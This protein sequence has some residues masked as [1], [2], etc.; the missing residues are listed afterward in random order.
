MAKWEIK[1]KKGDY[2][3]MAQVLSIDENVSKILIN[4]DINTRRKVR[5]YLNSELENLNDF[6]KMKDVDKAVK[7]L[8]N[9]IDK[10]KKITIYGDYDVDGVCSTTILYKGLKLL[11]QNISYYIP[12][13][14]TEGYGLNKK[15]I[16]KIK[17]EGSNLIITCDNGI[18]SFEE[19]ELAKELGMDVIIIDH[20]DTGEEIPKADSVINAKQEQCEFKFKEM[21][22]GGVSYRFIK[23]YLGKRNVELI[24]H[25]ELLVFSMIATFCDVVDLKEDNRIIATKGLEILN[26]NRNINLGLSKLMLKKKIYDKKI[27]EDSIG[28][29]IGPI[30]N[31][32]GRLEVASIAVDLF[33]SESPSKCD[34]MSKLLVDLNEER[35]KMTKVA[36]ESILEKVKVNRLYEKDIIV[37]Y[38]DVHESIAGIVAGRIK[39]YFYRPT[40][41]LTRGSDGLKGSARS[42]PPCNIFKVM[43]SNKE[44]FS[45]FG[46]HS[47]AAGFSIS[48][49]NY[50]VLSSRLNE[51][52]ELKEEDFIETI[53]FENEIK[54]ENITFELAEK[55]HRLYPYG[56]GNREPLFISKQMMVNEIR[57]IEDKN[58]I[59]FT[60]NIGNTFRKIKGITF[61]KVELFYNLLDRKYDEIEVS[62]IKKGILRNIDLK[63]NTVYSIAINEYNGNKSVQILIKDIKID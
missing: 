44:L 56:K 63:I 9:N 16:K 13:R 50:K 32:V 11:T 49:E 26:R 29:I 52:S 61:G 14:E 57:I 18:V 12:D 53:F 23:Y 48:E 38:G 19:V 21:C 62:K 33:V 45:K 10:E 37:V 42:I 54:I 34:E 22:A 20:H 36:Y 39:D 8:D 58:T 4:R 30:I 40:L 25:D 2:K 15:A 41:V 55:L 24:N 59:I 46:G 47:M 27:E 28:F 43:N 1:N 31:A 60:F 17:E 51:T 6:S 7:I 35:K 5:N 3:K